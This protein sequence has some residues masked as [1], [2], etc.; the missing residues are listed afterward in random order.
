MMRADR[1]GDLYLLNIN[2][3]NKDEKLCL[4]ASTSEVAW[5]WHNRFY[6]L[7]FHALEKL[8]KLNL[9]SDLPNIKFEMDHLCSACEVGKLKRASHRTKSD[10][11]YTK[12]VQLLHVDLCGPIYVQSVGGRKY[13][14]ALID[15]F[16]RYT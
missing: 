2:T 15:D 5:L 11:S 12:P 3:S 10:L 6:H 9:V 16:S 13:I 14:L 4:V 1:R 7:N 8:V